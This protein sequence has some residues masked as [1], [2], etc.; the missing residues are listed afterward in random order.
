VP[1][2]LRSFVETDRDLIESLVAA[3]VEQERS[4]KAEAEERRAEELAE[5]LREEA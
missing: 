2:W 3:A 4:D 1:I 5:L